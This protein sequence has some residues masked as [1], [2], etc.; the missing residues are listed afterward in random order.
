VAER[1]EEAM[2]FLLAVTMGATTGDRQ[3]TITAEG[4]AVVFSRPRR[5]ERATSVSCGLERAYWKS[6]RFS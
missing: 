5:C 1:G 3:M 6:S 2:R 4:D